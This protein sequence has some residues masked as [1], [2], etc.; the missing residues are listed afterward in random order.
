MNTQNI[1]EF[2]IDTEILSKEQVEKIQDKIFSDGKDKD[3]DFLE[4][5]LELNLIKPGVAEEILSLVFSIPRID[6]KKKAV[7]LE[8]FSVLPEPISP[9]ITQ[10][11][12]W[13]IKPYSNRVSA[14]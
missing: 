4:T 2:L 14:F 3:E 6:L 9:L 1:K 8:T 13:F 7:D 10:K 12:A 5:A 11:P